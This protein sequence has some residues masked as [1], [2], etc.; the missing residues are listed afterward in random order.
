M[1][2]DRR[3]ARVRFLGLRLDIS[4]ALPS[5][6]TAGRGSLRGD[7]NL[8]QPSFLLPHRAG[9]GKRHLTKSIACTIP[10]PVQTSVEPNNTVPA[11]LYMPRGAK[12][13]G[14]KRPA[15][16]CLHIMDGNEELVKISCSALAARG[17]PAL[18]FNL[19]FYGPRS[20]DRAAQRRRERSGDVHD[21]DIASRPG[22]SPHGRCPRRAAGNRPASASA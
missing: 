4:P 6:R 17:I 14:P 20:A 11:E 5:R 18:W 22:C 21:G 16:I 15:V 2:P 8:R 3:A 12:P 7:E 1:S 13:G 19:P 10:S 9:E